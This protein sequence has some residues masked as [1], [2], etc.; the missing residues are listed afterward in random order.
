MK[1]DKYMDILARYTSSIFQDF[2]SYLRTAVDL[3]QDDIRLVLDEYISSFIFY[4]IQPGIYTSKD[5]SEVLSRNPQSQYDA[6]NN[7]VDIE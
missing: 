2:Q 6:F 5:L 4:E 7:T 3:D 1:N